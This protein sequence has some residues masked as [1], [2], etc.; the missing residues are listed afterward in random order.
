MLTDKQITG[1]EIYL[2]IDPLCPECWALEPTL[3]KLV[4]EYGDYFTLRKVLSSSLTNLNANLQ[5]P[6][7]LA[8]HWERTASRTGMSCDGD[9]WLEQSLKSPSIVSLAIKAAELQGKRLGAKFLRKIQEELF[10]EKQDISNQHVLENCAKKV[11]LDVPVFAE[12]INSSSA[13]KA[14]QC[15]V[16]ITSE[17]EV[18][19]S[20]TLVF[21][22]ENIEDEGLKISG[23]YEYEIYV[24]ILQELA[25]Q[26]LT[27]KPLPSLLDFLRTYQFVGTNEVATVFDWSKERATKELKKLQF[28]QR[29]NPLHVKYGTFWQFVK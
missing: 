14:F 18:T 2:F 27:T 4:L 3:K 26:P 16:K 10:L 11:G 20:P 15:D 28:Q 5:N 7:H 29:V 19:E 1:L 22:N 12:D 23:L 8:N 6:Q 25:G 9:L 24:E 17:M 21:F 13:K